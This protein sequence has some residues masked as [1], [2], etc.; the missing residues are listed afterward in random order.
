MFRFH[1]ASHLHTFNSYVKIIVIK[2]KLVKGLIKM[3]MNKNI[4]AESFHKSIKDNAINAAG[5]LI[6]TGLDTVIDNELLKSVPFVSTAISLYRIGTTV[7]ERHHLIKLLTFI[8]EI[9]AGTADSAKREK[10]IREFEEN[11]EFREKE[12]N[13]IIIILDRYINQNKTKWLARLYLAYLDEIITLREFMVY[14]E[15]I[16]ALLPGDEEFLCHD[17]EPQGINTNVYKLYEQRFC[18]MGLF[19]QLYYYQPVPNIS[20][21]PIPLRIPLRIDYSDFGRK[22]FGIIF[23]EPKNNSKKLTDQMII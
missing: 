21:M 15:V 18:S 20:G 1:S 3:N 8:E 9:I 10:Y 13:Y 2:T 19:E 7:R 4:L 12:L 6:E 16:D 23:R 11:M 22:L 14:S 17:M 5:G